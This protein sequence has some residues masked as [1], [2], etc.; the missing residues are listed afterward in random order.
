MIGKDNSAVVRSNILQRKFDQL[1]VKMMFPLG[2]QR[3]VRIGAVEL[4]GS[5]VQLPMTKTNGDSPMLS[6]SR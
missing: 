2:K 3:N 1:R 4:H 6:T 5:V